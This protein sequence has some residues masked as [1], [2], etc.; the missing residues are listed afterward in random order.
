MIKKYSKIVAIFFLAFFFKISPSFA[1]EMTKEELAEYIHA[2]HPTASTVYIEGEYA[3]TDGHEIT[4]E[5]TMLAALSIKLEAGDGETNND[6]IW[7][8]MI[9]YRYAFELDEDFESKVETFSWEAN[10]T[11]DKEVEPPTTFNIKY[12]DYE[13]VPELSN[14]DVKPADSDALNEIKTDLGIDFANTGVEAK[15][16]TANSRNTILTGIVSP[17]RVI[18][19]SIFPSE[20]LTGYYYAFTIDGLNEKSTVTVE[21]VKTK[22]FNKDDFTNGTRL[23]VLMALHPELGKEGRNIKITVDADGEETV[24]GDTVYNIDYS[25]VEF[26]E[27][28][29]TELLT[30]ESELYALEGVKNFLSTIK[31]DFTKAEGLTL[32]NGKLTGKILYD[33]EVGKEFSSLPKDITGYYFTYVLTVEGEVTDDTVIT[34]PGN[35]G[36]KVV[37]KA[38]FDD[39]H[40]IV[41]TTAINPLKVNKVIEITVDLDGDG[42]ANTYTIDYSGVEFDTAVG[43]SNEENLKAALSDETIEN[44][45]LNDD[46]TSDVLVI[47]HD[48]KLDLNGKVLTA[49][50]K[51]AD[52]ANV[53]ICNGK[54]TS[55]SATVIAG[56]KGSD[57]SKMIVLL[58]N[59]ELVSAKKQGVF[60]Y[61]GKVEFISGKVT[62]QESALVVVEGGTLIVTDG[63]FNAT[64]NSVIATN[65]SN[66]LGN[67]TIVI[68]GGTYNGTI[69]SAG[70][71]ANG[72]YVA[73]ND[74]LVVNGGTFNITNGTG[75]LVRS[76]KATVSDKVVINVTKNDDL[77]A[78]WIGDSKIEV[79]NGKAIVVDKKANYPGGEPSVENNST[80]EVTTIE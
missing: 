1:R 6:P 56:T 32:K 29:T 55:D 3:F 26:Y 59:V 22:T 31:Y 61:G 5:D 51:I 63:T 74:E 35:D 17:N 76:G 64:D 46:V 10:L 36:T 54:I 15:A 24:Y 25:E 66:G 70:Y 9:I 48:M 60:Q 39:A 37:K 67:N 14:A 80:Y 44:I 2:T 47:N 75:I 38:S 12:V 19:E 69:T 65:G 33:G 34:I 72:I 49:Q 30:E 28:A 41:I 16:D 11:G 43:V 27:H 78:G 57:N 73:N 42:K 50:V 45:V 23:T 7:K 52:G 40:S 77:E 68:N 8:K 53:E 21:G 18:G 79:P 20:D 13:Y 4:R 62:A 71:I 58:E